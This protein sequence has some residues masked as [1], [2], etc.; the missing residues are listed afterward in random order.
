M[1]SAPSPAD[2]G[3]SLP[4]S[5]PRGRPDW[6][7]LAVVGAVG[8]VV[9]GV[10]VGLAVRLDRPDA[11]PPPR[12]AAQPAVG[13]P[14]VAPS[15][16]AAARTSLPPLRLVLDRPPPS[17]I[18]TLPWRAQ[19][20]RLQVL[21]RPAGAPARRLVELGS[22]YQAVG[23]G[24]EARD[25]YRAALRRS[26]GEVAA[27]AGLAMAEGAGS[28]QG[29]E[30]TAR[31]LRRLRLAHPRNQLVAFNEGW[32]AAYRRRPKETVADLRRAIALGPGTLLGRT[33]TGLVQRITAQASP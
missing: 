16:A 11:G 1:S 10:A 28:S 15:S 14:V 24:P 22:A 13:G 18:G 23:L 20:R 31:D 33:A 6:R 27:L 2:A 19:I 26:P 29:L 3:S 25:A 32:V 5:A 17:G 9:T 21:A 4:P 7:R 8:A 12:D 30:L